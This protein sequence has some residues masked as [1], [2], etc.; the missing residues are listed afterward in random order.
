[1]IYRGDV[2][3]NAEDDEDVLSVEYDINYGGK[4][5]TYV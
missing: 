5:W 4:F 2:A 1:M 3:L